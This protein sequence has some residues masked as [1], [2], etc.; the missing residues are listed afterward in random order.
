MIQILQKSHI[1]SLVIILAFCLF[2][3]ILDNP[4]FRDIVS[5]LEYSSIRIFIY[6]LISSIPV[7]ISLFILMQKRNVLSNVGL[8]N[9]FL[10]A[11]IFGAIVTI[12]MSIGGLLFGDFNANISL[13]RLMSGAVIAGF[14]EELFYRAFLFGLL[15]RVAK[16]GFIP[17]ILIASVI[18]GA[19]HL[20]Q[21]NDILSALSIFGVTAFGSIVFAWVYIEWNYN[22]WCAIFLHFFMNLWWM[23]FSLSATAQGDLLANIFRVMTIVLVVTLTIIYKKRLAIKYQINRKTLWVNR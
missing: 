2:Q 3:Y 1:Q 9:G 23:V 21:S 12:P 13:N 18:F 8:N 11:L 15:F 22:L 16:W 14:M 5:T 7:V 20:Y 19:V 17:S 10:T 4:P 6:Y